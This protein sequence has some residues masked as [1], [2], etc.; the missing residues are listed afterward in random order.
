MT[1]AKARIRSTPSAPDGTG[2]P[3]T[4]L[5]AAIGSAF[6]SSVAIPATVSASRLW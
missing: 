2:S 4:T 5:P 6:V 1:A 3:R